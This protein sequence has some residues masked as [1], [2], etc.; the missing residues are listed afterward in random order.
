A[1]Q[2]PTADRLRLFRRV[3]DAVQ[4]AHQNLL[5]HRDLK[6]ANILVTP[7]GEPKLLDFG[8]A[9]QL[10]A[11]PAHA[12]TRTGARVMTPHWASPEQVRGE[13][14]TPASDV[15]SLGV[16][17]YQLLVGRSPYRVANG[18]PHEIE[19]AICDE[20]P[21]PPSQALFRRVAGEASAEEL[22]RRRAARPATLR[23]ELRGD[24]DT[25]V[26]AALRKEPERRYR[27][28]AELAADLDNHL[29][30]LPLLMRG[31]SLAYRA[32]KLLRRRRAALL[33]AGAAALVAVGVAVGL[34][35][36]GYLGAGTSLRCRGLDRDV[37]AVW[38]PA[39]KERLGATFLASGVGYAGEVW[40]RVAARLDRY[41]RGIVEGRVAACRAS[42]DGVQS[43]RLLDLRMACYAERRA[44]LRDVV[45]GLSRSGDDA[46]RDAPRALEALSALDRCEDS[47]ALLYVPAGAARST[48]GATGKPA[49]AGLAEAKRR[50]G[51]ALLGM[52]RYDAGEAA[53]RESLQAAF[54]SG[55]ARQVAASAIDLAEASVKRT[56]SPIKEAEQW[57]WVAR[58]AGE[59]APVPPETRARLAA[60]S[61]EVALRNGDLG[62][63]EK[64]YTRAVGLAKT[65]VARLDYKIGLRRVLEQNAGDERR[66]LK[67]A[68]ETLALGEE[69]FGPHHP[70]TVLLRVGLAIELWRAG[71]PQE[72]ERVARRAGEDAQ[73]IR[74]LAARGAAENLLGNLAQDRADLGAAEP[75]FRSALDSYVRAYG[76]RSSLTAEVLNNLAEL[77]LRRERLEEAEVLRREVLAINQV[78]LGPRH[79]FVAQDLSALGHVLLLRGRTQEAADVLRDALRLTEDVDGRTSA[80]AGIAQLDLALTLPAAAERRRAAEAGWRI[81]EAATD[82]ASAD[83]GLAMSLYGELL[84]TS[85]RRAEGLKWMRRAVAFLDRVA[86]PGSDLTAEAARRLA[87]FES[88]AP[89]ARWRRRELS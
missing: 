47:R 41:G 67:L 88:S 1:R 43:A 59:A 65:V 39:T 70:E 3:C 32:R 36:L 31:D 30:H 55:D 72:A 51:R 60:V 66:A 35:A 42:A 8:I 53:L 81:V 83:R 64:E 63:A 9:K 25:I 7:A 38:D 12:L 80:E 57:L 20:E 37:R 86:G 85:G 46:I 11:E 14:V 4:H 28:A 48:A 5:V 71:Q 73:R 24:L 33:A 49:Q 21:A 54:T 61:G 87:R 29:R 76:R 45:A 75:H 17:L 26:A 27:S 23:R 74:L 77:A 50:R 84:A 82:E 62:L 78:V 69:V 44:E 10:A 68:R 15:Y 40:R 89:P 18:R 58:S 56:S 19:R 79:A 52:R 6:P 34:I 16:L 13:P 22:A 2:L